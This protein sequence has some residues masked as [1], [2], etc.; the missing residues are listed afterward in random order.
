[1][2]DVTTSG[3]GSRYCDYKQKLTSRQQITPQRLKV[4]EQSAQFLKEEI[5][6][7]NKGKSS[8]CF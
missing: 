3:S 8:D 6:G 5:A 1:M 7:T 2:F 4:L